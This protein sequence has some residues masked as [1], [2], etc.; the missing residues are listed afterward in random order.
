MRTLINLTEGW[1][2]VK[3]THRALVVMKV[4]TR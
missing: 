1:M 2:N 3:K 4:K